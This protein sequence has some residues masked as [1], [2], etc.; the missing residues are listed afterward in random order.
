[1]L[2]LKELSPE[3]PIE[4]QSAAN[5]LR[6][7]VPQTARVTRYY[8]RSI[9]LRRT[10]LI[11]FIC[12]C[13]AMAL[14]RFGDLG[15]HAMWGTFALVS[16]AALFYSLRYPDRVNLFTASATILCLDDAALSI[17]DP[18][19]HRTHSFARNEISAIQTQRV[20]FPVADKS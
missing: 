7:T 2:T 14:T 20:N 12:I 8:R 13:A 3:P 15:W 10:G 4:I 1:M 9:V 6:V 16:A 11:V 5:E 18:M 19:R 17:T